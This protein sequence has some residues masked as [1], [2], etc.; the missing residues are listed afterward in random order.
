MEVEFFD[1]LAQHLL[2]NHNIYIYHYAAL[3]STE[4]SKIKKAS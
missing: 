1:T 4:S 3:Q 2:T